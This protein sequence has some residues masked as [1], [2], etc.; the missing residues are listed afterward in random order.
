MNVNLLRENIY[1][2]DSVAF[3]CCVFCYMSAGVLEGTEEFIW[4][5]LGENGIG[6]NCNFVIYGY[7]M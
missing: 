2:T 5:D 7:S 1:E 6:Y 4:D 3:Y